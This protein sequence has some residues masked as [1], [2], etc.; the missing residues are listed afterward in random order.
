MLPQGPSCKLERSVERC[1]LNLVVRKIC[2]RR[3]GSLPACFCLL[4]FACRRSTDTRHIATPAKPVVG[5]GE[6]SGLRQW[7]E[8][9]EG[10]DL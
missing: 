3:A 4:P 8:V 7:G 9:R 6:A 2:E 1:N 10:S 5:T